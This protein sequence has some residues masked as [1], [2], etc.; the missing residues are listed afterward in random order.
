MAEWWNVN[1][2]VQVW[3]GH[4]ETHK[5]GKLHP[6]AGVS[7]IDLYNGS[8]QIDMDDVRFAAG[9]HWED[10][11]TDPNYSQYWV[12]MDDLSKEEYDPDPEPD[13]E[14]SNEEIGRVI[15]YLFRGE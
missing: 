6:P 13:P 10:L 5:Q 3:E 9:G 12:D 1:K 11:K 14:L 4:A 8:G 15:R 7:I 2:I